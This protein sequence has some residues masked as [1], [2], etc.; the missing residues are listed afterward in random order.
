MN[1]KQSVKSQTFRR[2]QEFTDQ[3]R[4]QFAADAPIGQAAAELS[5]AVDAFDREAATQHTRAR[6]GEERFRVAR[7]ALRFKVGAIAQTAE[8]IA[9]VK[10]KKSDEPAEEAAPTEEAA[11]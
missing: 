11:E 1:R 6:A 2:V 5:A 3:Y 8:V 7:E 9:Q 4:P 10:P